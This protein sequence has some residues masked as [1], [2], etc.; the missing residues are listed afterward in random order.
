MTA[1]G[2]LF[3]NTYIA[4][5]NVHCIILEDTGVYTNKILYYIIIVVE[6][7]VKQTEEPTDRVERNVFVD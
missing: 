7:S 5:Y 1:P 4:V 6:C 3:L 2:E